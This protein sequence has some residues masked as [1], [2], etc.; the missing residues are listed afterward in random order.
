MENDIGH[1][2]DRL[3]K[4]PAMNLV[5]DL[6]FEEQLRLLDSAG[7]EPKE[8][9]EMLGKT[10]D[11]IRSGLYQMRKKSKRRIDAKRKNTS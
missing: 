3:S 6:Q 10:S 1:K 5:K 8:M 7:F 11:A 2:I 4:L 9:E